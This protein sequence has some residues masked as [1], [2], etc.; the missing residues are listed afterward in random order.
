MFFLPFFE[1]YLK[2][3]FYPNFLNYGCK[4]FFLQFFSKTF[5]FKFFSLIFFHFSHFLI[6]FVLDARMFSLKFFYQNVPFQFF[7]IY[8]NF[9]LKIIFSKKFLK[10]FS[11]KKLLSEN[12]KKYTKKKKRFGRKIDSRKPLPTVDCNLAYPLNPTCQ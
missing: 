11:P 7:S 12:D 1:F 9:F 8:L 2:N 6:F 3:S 4:N 10:K 5:P